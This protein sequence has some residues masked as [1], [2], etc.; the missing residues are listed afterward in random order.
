M[1]MGQYCNKA[2]SNSRETWKMSCTQQWRTYIGVLIKDESDGPFHQSVTQLATDTLGF[3]QIRTMT[4]VSSGFRC[5][6][7]FL[8]LL[9]A[10]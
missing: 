3:D 5:S 9:V 1:W 8:L 7:L 4:S 6:L 2:L 10:S